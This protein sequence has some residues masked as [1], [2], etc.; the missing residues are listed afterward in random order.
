MTFPISYTG[1]KQ[2]HKAVCKCLLQH[3]VYAGT[4]ILTRQSCCSWSYCI[5]WSLHQTLYQM[6]QN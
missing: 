4:K 1:T 2:S 6:A 5:T 3:D